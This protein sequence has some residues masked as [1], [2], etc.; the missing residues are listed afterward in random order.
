MEF[1]CSD[2]GAGTGLGWPSQTWED[3]RVVEEAL[4]ACRPALQMAL[5]QHLECH[6]VSSEDHLMFQGFS[7]FNV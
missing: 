5:P 3:M 1:R 4:T 2:G 7:S 6:P